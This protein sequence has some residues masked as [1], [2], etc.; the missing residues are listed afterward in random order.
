MRLSS[1]LWV[2][3]CPGPELLLRRAARAAAQIAQEIVGIDAGIVPVAPEEPQSISSHIF[4]GG[5]ID[6]FLD[7]L[8]GEDP[9]PGELVYTPCTGAS[10]SEIAGTIER[11]VTIL[12]FDS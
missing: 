7:H 12:P 5:G 2:P 11:L 8:L 4:D 9:T 3:R 10:H 1:V 6:A